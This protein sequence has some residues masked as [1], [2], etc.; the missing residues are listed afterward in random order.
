MFTL[1][2]CSTMPMLAMASYG[3]AA[4]VA[5]VGDADLDLVGDAGGRGALARAGGLRLGQRD[6][7]DVG[8]VLERGVDGEGAPAAAHVEHALARLQAQLRA[9]ELALGVLRLLQRLGAARP[10][11]AR[12]RHR[13]AQHDL[14]ER[15]GDVVV[16]AHRA[17]VALDAVAAAARAQLGRRDARHVA[18]A[19]GAARRRRR[20]APWR[21]G[22]RAA[23][24]R[25][26]AARASRRCRPRRPRRPRRRARGRAGSAPAACG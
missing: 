8:A 1:P 4:Q 14:E 13:L 19:A 17:A 9:H 24:C 18:E 25:C 11:R 10:D 2:T 16:V 3:L 26:R 21:P 12:V 22:S 23:G 6:A 15:V 5:V 20:A 7:G